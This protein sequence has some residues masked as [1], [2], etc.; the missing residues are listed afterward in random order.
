M[1]VYTLLVPRIAFLGLLKFCTCLLFEQSAHPFKSSQRFF[2]QIPVENQMDIT[3]EWQ[4]ETGDKNDYLDNTCHFEKRQQRVNEDDDD[5]E[6]IHRGTIGEREL[7]SH[8]PLIATTR[9]ITT[10]LKV[11]TYYL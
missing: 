8:I 5:A 3:N 11:S 9:G 2:L 7:V 6:S 4:K 10:V 1:L